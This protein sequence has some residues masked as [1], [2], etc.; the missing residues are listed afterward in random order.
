MQARHLTCCSPNTKHFSPLPR[1][2][3]QSQIPGES[4]TCCMAMPL[5]INLLFTGLKRGDAMKAVVL[6]AAS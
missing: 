2:S 4:D 1:C 3:L 5:V 6:S